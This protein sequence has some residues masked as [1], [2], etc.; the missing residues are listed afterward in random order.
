[1]HELIIGVISITIAL[2]SL[3]VQVVCLYLQLKKP[4]N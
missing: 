1:M 3:I 4:R 2:L